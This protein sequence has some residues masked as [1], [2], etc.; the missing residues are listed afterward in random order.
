MLPYDVLPSVLAFVAVFPPIFYLWFLTSFERER[1]PP[2]V[3]AGLFVFGAIGA[4]AYNGLVTPFLTHDIFW[5]D[6][7]VLTA[8]ARVML[9]VAVPG[10]SLRWIILFLVCRR[11]AR[12]DQPMA[13]AVFG[14][15]LAF[16]FAAVENIGY[17]LVHLHHWESV[18]FVRTIV[19]VP[20]HGALGSVAGILMTRAR[21]KR[22]RGYRHAWRG[23]LRA[24]LVPVLLHG[25]YDI[26]FAFARVLESGS[27][28][29]VRVLR[30]AG[31][32]VGLMV[33]LAAAGLIYRQSMYEDPDF[34]PRCLSPFL[35]QNPWRLFVLASLLGMLGLIIL[36][37]EFIAFWLDVPIRME[38]VSII[39]IGLGLLGAAALLHRRAVA[40]R[41]QLFPEN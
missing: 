22:A 12:P 27:A 36:G 2:A 6:S 4:F 17:I 14:A 28:D 16:G 31:L 10:E 24:W 34:Q 37:A 40:L 33:F 3:V 30:A 9:L 18:A 1:E 15:S 38:R 35:L 19:T 13:G 7:E 5:L 32:V 29:E 25:L 21:F 20:V 11:F 23:Y 8:V 39:G 41:R 26:P